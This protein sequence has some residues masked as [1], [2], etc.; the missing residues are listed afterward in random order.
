MV[1]FDDLH[2][3]FFNS[4]NIL[5]LNWIGK[6]RIEKLAEGLAG[7]CLFS[8]YLSTSCI[9]HK[10]MNIHH[11]PFVTSPIPMQLCQ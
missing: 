4:K 8:A 10:I 9:R 6:L 1:Y 3:S 7:N 5:Q 2:F 11:L